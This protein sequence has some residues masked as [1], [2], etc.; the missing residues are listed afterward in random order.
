MR[1]LLLLVFCLLFSSCT[2][3]WGKGSIDEQ[4]STISIPY[5]EGDWEGIL[6]SALIRR[7]SANGALEVVN[8]GGDLCLSVCLLEP[9]REIIG[10]IIAPV[11]DTDGKKVLFSNEARLTLTA[12][13]TVTDKRSQC[14]L[15][16]PLEISA[17]LDYDYEPDLTSVDDHAFSLGQLEMRNLAED[18]ARPSLFFLLAEKIVDYVIFCW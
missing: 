17:Y 10:Y 13:V 15:F 8:G 12:V 18:A 3:K 14:T 1:S 16:G 6:T 11:E 2:Y 5:V 7:F 9:Q 4:Y